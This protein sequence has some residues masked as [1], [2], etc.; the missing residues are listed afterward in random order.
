MAHI[1]GDAV[2]SGHEYNVKPMAAGIRH[3]LV[4]AGTLCFCAGN[5][6]VIL[7][8]NFKSALAR[9]L[10][11]VQQLRFKVLVPGAHPAIKCCPFHLIALA[12]RLL[13]PFLIPGSSFRT[14]LMSR[15]VQRRTGTLPRARS[16]GGGIFLAAMYR[17]RLIRLM[18]SFRAASRVETLL[19]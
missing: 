1:S 9:H 7:A 8:H 17:W 11:E 12:L 6:I 5:N 2:K 19:I 15:S 13:R 18:P 14:R 10:A 16:F 4:E 3:E